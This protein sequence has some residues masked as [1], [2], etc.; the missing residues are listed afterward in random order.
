MVFTKWF[1]PKDPDEEKR[2]KELKQR[3]E[4][5]RQFELERQS[6]DLEVLAQGG[7]PVQA[8][9]RLEELG[10]N[11][12]QENCIFTSNLAPD[13][14]ALLR[15]HGYR[16]RGL[17]MGSAVWHVGQA[18]ASMTDCEVTVLS[19]AYDKATALA[20]S[21]MEQELYLIGG[22]GVV[23]V[24]LKMIR[25]EWGEKLVEVQVMGTAVQGPGNMPSRPFLSD[26]SVQE[27]W[28]LH[29]AGFDAAGLVWGYCTWFLFTTAQ[30]EF[31]HTS[32]G[33]TE[34]DHF[35]LGLGRAR[36][37]ALDNMHDQARRLGANGIVGVTIDRKLQEVRL[38][39]PDMGE[40]Q[41]QGYE[42][43]HHNLTVSIIGTAIRVNPNAPR[44]VE[45]TRDIL[46][47]KDGRIK[48]ALLKKETVELYD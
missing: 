25:H 7:I 6:I 40:M 47:L 12:D 45:R 29:R 48:P 2:R 17:V 20:V 21:R 8:K 14:L 24:T 43:E 26:L 39:G 11:A 23:G 22:H 35:S 36:N 27:W 16:P 18:F 42:R 30:D 3:I 4:D 34:F 9:Q 13:E 10:Q 28:A 37:R 15:R 33:N 46:S 41:N 44:A 1:G 5:V 38:R 31:I 32:F 19:H